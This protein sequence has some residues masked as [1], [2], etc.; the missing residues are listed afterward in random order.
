VALF[1]PLYPY[2]AKIVYFYRAYSYNELGNTV[3]AILDYNKYI[4]FEPNSSSSYNNRA[5]IYQKIGDFS[6]AISDFNNAIVICSD[7][8]LYLNNRANLKY[9]MKDYNGSIEDYT[10]I[11]KNIPHK[12]DHYFF[13]PHNDVHIGH[14]YNKRG[15]CKIA[16]N[17]IKGAV[18][19]WE[20]ALKMGYTPR[21]EI[22]E[23]LFKYK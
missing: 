10:N 1:E 23:K 9:L 22:K 12:K 4:E 5:L 20:T 19:D 14:Y 21:N 18:D 11:L 8:V 2:K 13:T 16:I 15:D 7:G 3:K 17:D 6:M